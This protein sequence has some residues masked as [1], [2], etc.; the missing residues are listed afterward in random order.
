MGTSGLSPGRPALG[1]ITAREQAGLKHGRLGMPPCT[2]RARA[3]KTGTPPVTLVHPLDM[4]SCL[5]M[6]TGC[7]GAA[8]RTERFRRG[9]RFG[10]RRPTASSPLVTVGSVS[11]PGHGLMNAVDQGGVGA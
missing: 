10:L 11:A 8:Q 5:C 1:R 4:T 7:D 3:T 6:I 9:S 2:Q